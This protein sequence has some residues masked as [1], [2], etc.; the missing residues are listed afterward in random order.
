[1]QKIDIF[2]SILDK[3]N[4]F[5]SVFMRLKQFL[6]QKLLEND[7]FREN[8]F[9]FENLVETKLLEPVLWNFA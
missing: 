7:V 5:Y 1:M 2:T 4:H 3:S 8:P 6:H 9:K